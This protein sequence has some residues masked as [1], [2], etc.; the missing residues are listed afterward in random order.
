MSRPIAE[1][2]TIGVTKKPLSGTFEPLGPG[3]A[4]PLL[5]DGVVAGCL[6]AS[7]R[8]CRPVVM[9]PGHM[10]FVDSALD[11]ALRYLRGHELHEPSLLEHRHA[12]DIKGRIVEGWRDH[13][14]ER[15][16]SRSRSLFFRSG[17]EL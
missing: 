5:T 13:Q 8:G 6:L 11:L 10:V 15:S 14:P 2:A 17:P 1:Q 3:G 9:A 7:K 12:N 4:L 16:L